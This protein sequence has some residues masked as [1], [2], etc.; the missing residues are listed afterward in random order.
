[1]YRKS[2]QT[3][4]APAAIGPYSQA[5][6]TGETVYL[7]GQIPIDPATGQLISDDFEVQAH[8]VLENLTAVARASGGSLADVVKLTVFLSDL[9]NFQ[10]LNAAFADHFD[11][12]FPAR[13]TIEV[14]A[15]PLGAL[16]EVDAILVL[17][18]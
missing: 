15:L 1:M 11:E 4:E 17:P 16:V 5:I 6:S 9:G 14:S 12:P 7:S 10:V 18:T 8:Q 3:D 2:I 13:S